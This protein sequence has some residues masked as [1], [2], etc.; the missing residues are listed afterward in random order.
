M[1]VG[2]TEPCFGVEKELQAAPGSSLLFTAQLSSADLSQF[3]LYTS[4]TD[5]VG[6]LLNHAKDGC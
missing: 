2:R 5:M 3:S 6:E 4:Y 1:G